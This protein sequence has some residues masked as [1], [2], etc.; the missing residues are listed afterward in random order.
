MGRVEE[1]HR[2][3][4]RRNGEQI[5]YL[6]AAFSPAALQDLI[7]IVDSALVT[8]PNLEALRAAGTTWLSRLPDN[9]GAAG[10]AKAAA[11]AVGR[12]D[13]DRS[14]AGDGVPKPPNMGRPSLRPPCGTGRTASWFTAASARISGR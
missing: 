5:P 1:G 6:V 4:N 13:L 9:F 12:G 11:W 14:G 3:D 10:T 7:Y 2:T 8:R